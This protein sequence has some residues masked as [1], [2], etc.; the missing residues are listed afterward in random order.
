MGNS[1][2]T[3]ETILDEQAAMGIY[4]PRSAPSGFNLALI[5]RLAND[6]M[7][8]LITER[9]NWKFNRALANPFLTNSFQQD[10]PLPASALP[11]GPIGWGDDCDK[12]DINNTMIPKPVNVPGAPKW[13]RNL[14]RAA[15]Q[16]NGIIGGPTAI[17]W[18]YNLDMSYGTWPGASTVFSPLITTGA[19][20]QNPIMNFIDANG[21]FLIL[22]GFGT[23]GLTQPIAA[24]NAAEGVTVTDGTCT[25]MVVSGTSQ[26]FRIWP[27][28]SG[29]GPVYQMIPSYQLDPPQFTA[30]ANTINPIPNSYARHFRRA[31]AYQCKGA[32]S[33]PADKQEFLREYPMW[34]EGL[35]KMPQDADKEENAYG[36]VPATSPVDNIWPGNYRYTADQPL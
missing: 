4:D 16:V 11:G 36:L 6:T 15:A 32:S 34:L 20:A 1:S 9:F 8:D 12:I 21:N 26:G 13:K 18:M 3:I 7:A 5:L 31:F 28:P 24:V 29:T 27:L 22:T 19:V 10:Y 35:K 23:T 2:L 17:A 14:P 30:L 33:N 25:W